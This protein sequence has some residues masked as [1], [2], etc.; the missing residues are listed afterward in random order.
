MEPSDLLELPR[1]QNLSSG[2]LYHWK[3]QYARG[4]SNNEPTQE[5]A[6]LDR[7]NK[8]EQM[9]GKLTQKIR[10]FKKALQNTL[11]EQEKDEFIA[12]NRS[13]VKSVRRGCELMK[14][15]RSTLYHKPKE[16]SLEQLKEE[17][18]LRDRI[19]RI[20][21]D[22]PRYVY[23]RVTKQLQRESWIVNHKRVLRV[24]RENDLLCRIRRQRIRTTDANHSYPVFPNLI[25]DLV[26]TCINEVSCF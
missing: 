1:R 26:I 14:I 23:R 2:L 7:I 3:K 19:E 11:K 25:K 15:A 6:L 9:L 21:L 18:D 10:V 24:M 13:L 8:L 12:T 16:K 5:E 20:C 17:M 4:K 22:F